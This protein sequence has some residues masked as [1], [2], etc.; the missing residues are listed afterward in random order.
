MARGGSDVVKDVLTATPDYSVNL[1]DDPFPTEAVQFDRQGRLS[2]T[3]VLNANLDPLLVSKNRHREVWSQ[4]AP[5]AS[6][7][8][9]WRRRRS[10][11]K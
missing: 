4:A 10:R 3:K 1:S 8:F 6:I 9:P 7:S 5:L 2:Y 11:G